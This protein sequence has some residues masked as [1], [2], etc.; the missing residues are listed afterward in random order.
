MVKM[1]K[2]SAPAAKQMIS[3]ALQPPWNPASKGL[4]S[5]RGLQTTVGLHRVLRAVV[6][7]FVGDNGT[8]C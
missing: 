7:H 3:S 8:G 4:N 1:L 5:G 2:Y 6:K